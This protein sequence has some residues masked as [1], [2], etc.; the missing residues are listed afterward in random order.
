MKVFERIVSVVLLINRS[1]Y[2]RTR[3]EGS[4]ND[5]VGS[6]KKATNQLRNRFDAGQLMAG[7][8]ERVLAQATP[9][10]LYMRNNKLGKRHSAGGKMIS[11]WPS[12][13]PQ[14]SRLQRCYQ[15][16]LIV[17]RSVFYR[18]TLAGETPE[19]Q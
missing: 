5:A 2:D 18:D 8:V 11:T 12:L 16:R 14:A 9:I 7:E 10:D 4:M 6:F 17:F 3:S 13:G 15:T 1:R 19:V